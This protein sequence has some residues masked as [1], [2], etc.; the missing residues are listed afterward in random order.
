[1]ILLDRL[2]IKEKLEKYNAFLGQNPVFGKRKK[3]KTEVFLF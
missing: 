3:R 2:I 1:M